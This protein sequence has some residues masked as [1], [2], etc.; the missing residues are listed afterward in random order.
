MKNGLSGLKLGSSLNFSGLPSQIGPPRAPAGPVSSGPPA[1]G[2]V[3][4]PRRTRCVS[5]AAAAAAS[6][7][8][9][10]RLLLEI[11]CFDVQRQELACR[12]RNLYPEVN[13]KLKLRFFLGLLLFF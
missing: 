11:L 10:P 2:V 8:P 3:L 13:A 5:A 12:S 1:E 7:H 4:Y 6:L 9:D